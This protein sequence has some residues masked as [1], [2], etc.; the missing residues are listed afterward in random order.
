MSFLTGQDRTPKFARQV[1]G[2]RFGVKSSKLGCIWKFRIYLE[3]TDQIN[4]QK[5]Y[6]KKRNLFI[7]IFKSVKSP[8]FWKE[9][10][11]FP[12][13]PYFENF[14]DFQTGRF[15]VKPYKLDII[16]PSL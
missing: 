4:K 10:V 11:R 9:N 8:A 6:E 3:L 5:K 15:P 1:P 12:D 7:F 16:G 2:H 14:P 13:I